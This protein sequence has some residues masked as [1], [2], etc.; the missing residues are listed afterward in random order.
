MTLPLLLQTSQM[1]RDEL[2]PN[3]ITDKCADCGYGAAGMICCPFTI[4]K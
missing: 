1:N 4:T 2:E 3:D